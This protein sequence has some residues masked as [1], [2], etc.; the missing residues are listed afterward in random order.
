[1]YLFRMQANKQW[2]EGKFFNVKNKKREVNKI[3]F[4][5]ICFIREG[6]E[7]LNIN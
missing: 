3:P 2:S 4:P 6:D 5:F 7:N 1:M